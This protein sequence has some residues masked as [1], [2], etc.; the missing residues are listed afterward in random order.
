MNMKIGWISLVLLMVLSTGC[1][2]YLN[3]TQLPAGTIA[4]SDAFVSDNSVSAIVTGNFLN[5]SGS[6]IFS[7]GTGS[8]IAYLTAL[9]TDETMPIATTNTTALAFYTNNINTGN[10]SH[11]SDLY[12]K[13][14]AVNAA[15]EGIKNATV[16]LYSKNQWLGES[17]FTRALLYFYLV[18]LY[19][20]APLALTT[21]YK[22]NGSLPRSPKSEVYQQIITD[23]KEAQT[24][25]GDD[26]KDGYGVKTVPRVRP[27]KA[28]ATA[29]LAKVYLYTK[30]WEQ[31]EAAATSVLSNT[32]YKLSP[33]S[34]VFIADNNA[35][36]ETI[37]A[38]AT[39][40]DEKA[41]E[42][43]FYNNG[44]PATVT[45][46][47]AL[48][49]IVLAAL[50]SQMLNSFEANDKR[51]TTWVRSTI[52]TGVTPA[53]TYYFPD[54]FKSAAVGA[55]RLVVLRLADL[56]LV[57]AEARV[58]RNNTG[59]ARSD[60]DSVRVRAG[61]PVTTA[62]SQTDLLTAI[63]K[64]RRVEFFTECS[65]RF[66]DLKRT[67]A[68]DGV[69]KLVAPLKGGSWET[70]KQLLPIPESDLRLNPALTPNPGY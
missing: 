61:L 48:T 56:Y 50:S 17:Y 43:G 3:N 37:W 55:E 10:T 27:N 44:M 12:A 35:N 30:N 21:D 6:A 1:E 41:Y 26:Y 36:K 46:D 45:K 15:I 2:K 23:L 24:L 58:Q 47:P 51:F 62:T 40:S 13:I 60:L 8:N 29:F 7:G 69:M 39:R 59:D 22:L 25:L 18:N 57:R 54:K 11:W 53:I 9:Y 33:L 42:Y 66:F 20:D 63:A 14:Y 34:Q 38:L 64:E 28:A 16:T 67:D 52:Y 31:A 5:L 49:Y 19:G 68:I 65:N 70:F 32:A 4:G